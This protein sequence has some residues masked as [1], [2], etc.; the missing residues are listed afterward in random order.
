MR[1]T[2]VVRNDVIPEERDQQIVDGI[3]RD[4][5]DDSK[6]HSQPWGSFSASLTG[7]RR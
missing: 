4:W 2:E 7:T 5:G 6:A 1:C 3:S